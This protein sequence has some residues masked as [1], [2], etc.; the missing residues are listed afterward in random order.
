VSKKSK[1]P[2][3]AGASKLLRFPQ[4]RVRPAGAGGERKTLG[5]GKLAAHLGM[6][7]GQVTGHWCSRCAGIWYGY[8]F[9]VECPVCGNRR[10]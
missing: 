9:E 1:P 10:G 5:T 4:S 2:P 7:E 3:A 6:T 8:A